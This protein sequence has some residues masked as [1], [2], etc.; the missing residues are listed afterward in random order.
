MNSNA[1]A[2]SVLF[3]CGDDRTHRGIADFCDPL[4]NISH[5]SRFDREL[6][7]VIDVLISAS[8]AT[9]EIRT[10]RRNSMRGSFDKIDK[11]GFGELI[12]VAHDAG[13]H[14]FAVNGKWD[15][16]SFAVVASYSLAT[17]RHIFDEKIDN[18]HLMSISATQR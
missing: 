18:A 16:D 8:A 1:I 11:L 14:V 6:M 7:L 12:F 3:G 15:E 2:V 13:T 17:E 4:Q 5:L 10:R 9:A